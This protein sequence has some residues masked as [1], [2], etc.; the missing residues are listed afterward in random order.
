MAQG[1]GAYRLLA[2]PG[3]ARSAAVL[4]ALLVALFVASGCGGDSE[5]SGTQGT[6]SS[7][8]SA[9][10]DGSGADATTPSSKASSKQGAKT[11]KGNGSSPASS[12]TSQPNQAQGKQAPPP[13]IPKGPRE[14]EATP[15]QRAEA[16]VASITLL[17]PAIG[18]PAGESTSPLPAA[19][20]CNGKDTSPPLR[21][22]G[23][24]A[25]TQE[26]VLFVM[27]LVP[28]NEELFFD[29]ALA[30]IDPG[31]EELKEGELPKGAVLGRNGHGNR[32]YSICPQGKAE[33]YIF[34]LYALPQRLN[35]KPGFDPLTLRKEVMDLSGNVGLM[36]VGVG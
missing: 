24:P 10:V 8:Q 19:Y 2:P 25:G 22:S 33:T 23:V 11:G 35:A 3:K 13:A 5:D 20:T 30:G 4:A 1:T 31:L 34:A 16:T 15:E 17:S 32:A 29:W 12:K 28:V 9:A 21:W 36:A 7:T 18:A 6:Q 14:P 27:N 26:L